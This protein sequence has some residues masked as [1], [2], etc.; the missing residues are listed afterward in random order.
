MPTLQSLVQV[1]GP[2]THDVAD[3]ELVLNV[4]RGRPA[5]PSRDTPGIQDLQVLVATDIGDYRVDQWVC[6]AV[7]RAAERL[8]QLGATVIGDGKPDVLN[9]AV[10]VYSRLRDQDSLDPIRSIVA[11]REELLSA[12]IRNLL[13]RP[14]PATRATETAELAWTERRQLV[15]SLDAALGE[16]R[17]LVLPVSTVPPFPIQERPINDFDVLIPSRAVSLFGLPALAVPVG[18][19]PDGRPLSVQVVAPRRREDIA[20]SA[21]RALETASI[22][23]ELSP[24]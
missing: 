20:F 10:E 17:I 18:R 19:T 5:R 4:L 13:S 15:S 11:G 2:L 3:A 8:G 21:A 16:N 14:R 9:R 6:H 1:I 7:H 24:C 23:E 12:H 22:P